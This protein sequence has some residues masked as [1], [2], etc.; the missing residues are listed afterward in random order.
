MDIEKEGKKNANG[1][2]LEN[3]QTGWCS[4]NCMFL[5]HMLLGSIF[6]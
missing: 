3:T 6:N 5:S 4:V 1:T 2:S